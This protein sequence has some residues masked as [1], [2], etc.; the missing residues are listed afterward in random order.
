AIVD[1]EATGASDPYQLGRIVRLPRIDRFSIS[2]ETAGDGLYIGTLVGEGLELIDRTGWTA[3]AG[4]GV[5]GIATPVP[6][7]PSQQTLRIAVAWPSPSPHAPLYVWL[8][9]E[10]SARLTTVKY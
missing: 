6:D 9:G 10:H 5:L 4:S 7:A 2:D 1:N 8:V 3:T